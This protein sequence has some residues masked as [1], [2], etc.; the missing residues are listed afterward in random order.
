[1]CGRTIEGLHGHIW[2]VYRDA[3]VKFVKVGNHSPLINPLNFEIFW[4]SIWTML[5]SSKFISPS[6]QSSVGNF[7]Y[8]FAEQEEE[9]EDEED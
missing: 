4:F 1:M 7:P 2:L 5:H 3:E 9:K 8:S 6:H